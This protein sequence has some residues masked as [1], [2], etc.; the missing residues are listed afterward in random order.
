MPRVG[1][2]HN[3]GSAPFATF[4]YRGLKKA[5]RGLYTQYGTQLLSLPRFTVAQ[6]LVAAQEQS[7]TI[8]LLLDNHFHRFSHVLAWMLSTDTR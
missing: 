6:V 1:A 7:S 2:D 3:Y 4:I 5:L 8:S